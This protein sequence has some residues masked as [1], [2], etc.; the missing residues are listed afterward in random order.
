MNRSLSGWRLLGCVLGAVAMAGPADA[1]AS[2]IRT[3]V[4]GQ[5]I[6]STAPGD[7]WGAISRGRNCDQSSGDLRWDPSLGE[8]AVAG[9]PALFAEVLAGSTPVRAR[10]RL[11]IEGRIG[12]LAANLCERGRKH[13]AGTL[14]MTVTWRVID[15]GNSKPLSVIETRASGDAGQMAADAPGP[16]FEAAFRANVQAL[17]DDPAF[18]KAVKPPPRPRAKPAVAAIEVPLAEMRLALAA[19]GSPMPLEQAARG[20]VSIITGKSLGS[21]LLI[22]ADGYLLTNAHVVG[23]ASA[24]TVRWPDGVETPGAVVRIEPRRDVALVKTD[25]PG[26]RPLA[27][28]RRPVALAETVFAIGTPR[29]TQFAGTLTRGVVSTSQRVI[30]GQTFI[31]S[32]VAITHGDSGGPLLDEKGWVVGV[33]QSTYEPGG[34]SQNINFFIPIDEALKALALKPVG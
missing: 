1:T 18:R 29:E 34:V 31:Q 8:A 26:V 21:G 19:P 16:L 13:V 33:T 17:I 4:L 25:P 12:A 3:L 9:F 22:T 7:A 30:G 15:P 2:K 14:T 23:A 28:R 27:I 20:V 24:V 11:R 32:D 6:F 10:S 5:A